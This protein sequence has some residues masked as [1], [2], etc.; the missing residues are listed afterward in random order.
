MSARLTRSGLTTRRRSR[1]S[2]SNCSISC[3]PWGTA[4]FAITG[5]TRRRTSRRCCGSILPSKTLSSSLDSALFNVLGAIR[6]N[7]YFPAYSNGLKDIASFL[8]ATWTGRIASGIECIARRLRW[9]ET[10]DSVIKE[11][12]IE[13]NRQDC[14][15]VQRVAN[16]LVIAW[17]DRRYGQSSSSPGIRDHSR[18]SRKIREDRLCN[19]GNE[20]HQ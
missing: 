20:L 16:F 17:L 2:G 8:G 5:V 1:R 9:E 3:V 12:I 7:V 4:R 18:F 19:P 13:Y 11:E 15:A 14:M 10:K 6:T